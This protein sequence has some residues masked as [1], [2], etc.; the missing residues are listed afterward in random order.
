MWERQ[1]PNTFSETDLLFCL[2]LNHGKV[3]LWS[4]QKECEVISSQKH[5][6]HS[7]DMNTFGA[8]LIQD[9]S[10]S[11]EQVE[12]AAGGPPAP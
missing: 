4:Y 2:L 6:H 11:L 7:S 12:E 9:L 10:P 3:R 5:D 1:V 8:Y